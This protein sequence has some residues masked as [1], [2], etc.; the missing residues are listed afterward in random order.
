VHGFLFPAGGKSTIAVMR[1]GGEVVVMPFDVMHTADELMGL[2]HS[3]SQLK[4][5]VRV[6]M[7][8]TSA[9]YLPVS[10]VLSEAGFFVSV[11]HAKLIHDFGNNSIRHGKTDKKDALKIANYALTNWASLVPVQKGEGK[12]YYVYMTATANRFLR[13]YYGKVRECMLAVTDPEA[14]T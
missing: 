13:C 12:P 4:G 8:N 14:V 10:T 6:V 2:A 11:V 7:E 5:T 1:P 9:Y 3:L